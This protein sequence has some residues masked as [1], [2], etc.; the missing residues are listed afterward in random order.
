MSN[1]NPNWLI[2]QDAIC[3]AFILS[4]GTQ[5]P[6]REVIENMIDWMELKAKEEDQKLTEDFIYSNIPTYINFLFDKS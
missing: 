1:T 4:M 2:A 5:L 6:R 3:K